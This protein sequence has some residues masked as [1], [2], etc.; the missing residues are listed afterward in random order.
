MLARLVGGV[1]L[2]FGLMAAPAAAQNLDVLTPARAGQLQ[3]F[4]P[5]VAA[6]TCQSLGGFAF[7]ADGAAVNAAEI[8]LMPQPLIVMRASSTV[9]FEGDNSICGPLRREDIEAA[10]FSV[11]GAPATPEQTAQLKA[12]MQEQLAPMFGVQTCM[13]LTQDGEGLRA[14]SIVGGTPRP[15]L[16]QRMIWVGANDGWR[17]AP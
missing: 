9:T 8:L 11:D 15:E 17:V 7:N 13:T 10:T 16:S 12:A 3:C 2:A 6:K 4:E 5:N 1:A 14:H